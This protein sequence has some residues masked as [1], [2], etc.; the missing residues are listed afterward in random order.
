MHTHIRT[1]ARTH[2]MCMY[3]YMYIHSRV[4]VHIKL[5]VLYMYTTRK[6]AL[7]RRISEH[8]ELSE[9]RFHNTILQT[10]KRSYYTLPKTQLGSTD[11]GTVLSREWTP[12]YMYI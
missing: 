3:M 2:T 4:K 12:L 6:V 10:S 11:T 5:H 7:H 9:T 8:N 1:R